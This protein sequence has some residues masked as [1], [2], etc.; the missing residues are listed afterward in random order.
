MLLSL[1]ASVGWEFGSGSAEL[2][3]RMG[4]L[5]QLPT[6]RG[7]S[8]P[9]IS[10]VVPRP[11]LGLSRRLARASSQHGALREADCSCGN[12]RAQKQVFQKSRSCFLFYGPASEVT[13]VPRS[14]GYTQV[15]IPPRF[16]RR[17]IRL[18][19]LVGSSKQG[20][21][22]ACGIGDIAA[23]TFGKLKNT[24]C[25]ITERRGYFRQSEMPSPTFKT[26]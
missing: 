25:H 22:R 18:H 16:K 21:G 14:I 2:N 17:V 3:N 1:V 5:M 24:S 11:L 20:S 8:W 7:W 19:L 12:S 15:T 13:L 9:G 6:D 26:Y 4:S 10:L 23:A